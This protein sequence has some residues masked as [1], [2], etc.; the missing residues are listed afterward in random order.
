[1]QGFQSMSGFQGLGF[2]VLGFRLRNSIQRSRAL[3]AIRAR[4][5]KLSRPNHTFEVSRSFL[6]GVAGPYT[7]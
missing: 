4:S 6:T 1:M 5:R 7:G 2:R 3:R